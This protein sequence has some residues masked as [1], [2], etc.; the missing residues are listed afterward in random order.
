MISP[1]DSLVLASWADLTPWWRVVVLYLAIAVVALIV[2][3]V[4]RN[5]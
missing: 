3:W 4:W 1:A 2:E 5:E